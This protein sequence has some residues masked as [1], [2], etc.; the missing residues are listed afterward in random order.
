MAEENFLQRRI[1]HPAESKDD[2]V[3][4]FVAQESARVEYLKS[5]CQEQDGILSQVYLQ[6]YLS[7]L[8]Y[9]ENYGNHFL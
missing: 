2:A 8:R 3:S 4:F 6:S 7:F 9:V 5:L 1:S